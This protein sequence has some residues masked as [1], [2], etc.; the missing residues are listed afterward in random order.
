[1]NIWIRITKA[2]GTSFGDAINSQKL[3]INTYTVTNNDVNRFSCKDGDFK[4]SII[5][6]PYDKGLSSYK[7]LTVGDGSKRFRKLTTYNKNM[8]YEDFL[9]ASIDLRGDHDKYDHKMLE[10]GVIV[11]KNDSSIVEG[12]IQ[13]EY[14]WAV[15]HL[16]GLYNTITTFVP[17]DDMDLLVKLEEINE[18]VSKIG[19]KIG[20]T[21]NMPHLNKTRNDKSFVDFYSDKVMIPFMELYKEDVNNFDYGLQ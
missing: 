13:Y 17:L 6:N 10:S 15:Q 5:R 14:F 20:R 19:E 8:S 3:P 18:G 2:G 1:V 9:K 12:S 4:F 16:E 21:I 7:W 11:P